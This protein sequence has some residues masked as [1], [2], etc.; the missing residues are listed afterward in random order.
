LKERAKK[1]VQQLANEKDIRLN[2]EKLLQHTK[3]ELLKK[4]TESTE[5]RHIIQQLQR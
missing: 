5:Q 3:K 1:L 4:E 2:S